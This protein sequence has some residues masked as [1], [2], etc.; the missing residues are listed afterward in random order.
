VIVRIMS[1]GQ[2]DVPE[3]ALDELNELDRVVEEAVEAGD[4]QAFSVALA[5]LL[6]RVRSVGR[7]VP[8]EAL[9]PSELVLPP[10]DATIEDV[11]HLFD[12]SA[13]SDGLVPG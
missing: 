5:G 2:L 6:E 10:P 11:R 9:V 1:E 8:D 3:T 12:G 4:E 13:G 7:A